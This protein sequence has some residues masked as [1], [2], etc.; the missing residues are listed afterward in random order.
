MKNLAI[1]LKDEL[2]NETINRT[3][4]ATN[5]MKSGSVCYELGSDEEQRNCIE[6]CLQF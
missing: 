6:R 2:T 5:A 1:T 3:I 4:C